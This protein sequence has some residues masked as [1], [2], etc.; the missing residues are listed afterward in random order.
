[1]HTHLGT[2]VAYFEPEN[3]TKIYDKSK[4]TPTKYDVSLHNIS[5]HIVV[6]FIL[7]FL[8]ITLI[9]FTSS[10]CGIIA[11]LYHFTRVL[12]MPDHKVN[13]IVFVTILPVR[14]LEVENRKH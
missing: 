4:K 6:V 5:P 11:G 10:V 13:S 9:A 2:R 1:M 8:K 7:L 14:I 3:M 12:L